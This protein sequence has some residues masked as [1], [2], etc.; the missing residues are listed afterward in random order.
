MQS[1][2]G[3]YGEDIRQDV[4]AEALG[5]NEDWGTTRQAIEHYAR[6][7]GYLVEV[8]LNATIDDL[9]TLI[10][11]GIPPIVL[12]QAWP[13]TIVDWGSDMADGHYVVAVGYNDNQM[14]FMD[15]STFGNYTAI[16]LEEF[17]Q[18]WHDQ[19]WDGSLLE[20]FIMT[21]DNGHPTFDRDRILPL[22]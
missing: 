5:S 12:L 14:Y 1:V 22:Q 11:H 7:K 20:H 4:L 21:I 9:R 17:L 6:E 2:L 13:E 18:R 16:P 3:Y 8:K 19:D 10:D 15:P